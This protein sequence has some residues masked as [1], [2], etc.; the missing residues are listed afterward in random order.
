MRGAEHPR[1]PHRRERGPWA[2][3]RLA[4]AASSPSRRDRPGRAALQPRSPGR[5]LLTCARA[6]AGG[7]GGRWGRAT[8]LPEGA[9]AWTPP[10]APRRP[11]EPEPEPSRFPRRC[12]RRAAPGGDHNSHNAARGRAARE[13]ARAGRARGGLRGGAGRP[14]LAPGGAPTGAASPGG[15]DRDARLAWL[16]R[17]RGPERGDALPT[18][19]QGA[20]RRGG[21]ALIPAAG[22][23]WLPCPF[24]LPG[25]FLSAFWFSPSY[26]CPLSLSP[27][28]LP[29]FPHAPGM[30]PF[31]P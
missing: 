31:F 19:P 22:S 2:C 27:T 9:D 25:P 13:G 18:R 17:G 11:P 29:H 20:R 14:P 3:S 26:I 5:P 30:T 8:P 16:Q 7:G 10:P 28:F 15:L 24:S 23:P 12:R 4:P 6:R 21:R 1:K